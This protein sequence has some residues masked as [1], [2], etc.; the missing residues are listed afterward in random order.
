MM[1]PSFVG[2]LAFAGM[3]VLIVMGVPIGF[4]MLTTAVVGY[5]IIR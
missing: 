3:M 4:A 2:I 1:D 5:F